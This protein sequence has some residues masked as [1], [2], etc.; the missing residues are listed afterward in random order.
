MGR[1]QNPRFFTEKSGLKLIYATLIRVADNGQRVGITA[2]ERA[3]LNLL[4]QGI[5]DPA[6]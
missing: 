3:Q 1:Q 6:R 4:Y 5:G 2:T